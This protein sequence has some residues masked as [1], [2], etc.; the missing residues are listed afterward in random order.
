[1]VFL[2]IIYLKFV[3]LRILKGNRGQKHAKKRS[4]H[5]VNEHFECV[6]N[7]LVQIKSLM[8]QALFIG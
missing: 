1:M 6:F 5:E 2:P 3:A 7:R 8:Q 4:L